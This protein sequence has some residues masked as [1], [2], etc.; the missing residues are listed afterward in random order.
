MLQ[1]GLESLLWAVCTLLI[2]GIVSKHELNGAPLSSVTVEPKP[3]IVFVN[4]GS[5]QQIT[6]KRFAIVDLIC[7]GQV[8]IAI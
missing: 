3:C 1:D 4:S 6:L 7:F 2:G 8:V 5:Y